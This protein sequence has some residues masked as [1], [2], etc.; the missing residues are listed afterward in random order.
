MSKE[1]RRILGFDDRWLMIMGIPVVAIMMNTLLFATETNIPFLPCLLISFGYTTSFWLLFRQGYV[2]LL[3]RFGKPEDVIKRLICTA[4]MAIAGYLVINF[5]VEWFIKD[6]LQ[7]VFIMDQR[8]KAIASFLFITI[9]MGIYEALI[10]TNRWKQVSLEKE[11]LIKENVNSQ[12]EGLRNQVNPHFLFNSLNTLASIIPE[13]PD[14]GVDFVTKLAK[15]YR[16][17]LEGRNENLI[18]LHEELEFLNAYSYLLKQRFGENLHISI[19]LEDSVKDKLIIPLSLQLTFENAIKHNII[20]KDKPLL[21]EIFIGEK[22]KLVVRNTLQKKKVL[23]KST[24]VGLQNI[25]NRY[26]FYT[27]ETVDVVSS[28]KYFSVMLPL[29]NKQRVNHGA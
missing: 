23:G 5:L 8:L 6:F 3:K 22:N 24:K 28:V 2:V 17:M 29:I 11:M 1:S 21:L 20:S 27:D 14:K 25:I 7:L 26:A 15:V 13:N 9:V 19:K 10:L 18:P 12:L 4:M 16:Y